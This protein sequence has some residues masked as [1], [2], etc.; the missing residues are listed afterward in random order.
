MQLRARRAAATAVTACLCVLLLAGGAAARPAPEKHARHHG[1]GAKSAAAQS[2]S[3]SAAR[4][5]PLRVIAIGDSITQGSVPSANDNHPYTLEL[6]RRLEEAKLAR[7]VD[8]DNIAV[9]GAGVFAVGFHNPV[10]LVPWA[11]SHLEKAK[12]DWAVV[13]VGINDLLRESRRADDVSGGRALLC[14]LGGL[15][16]GWGGRRC[17]CFGRAVC[18]FAACVARGWR[19]AAAAAAAALYWREASEQA[20]HAHHPLPHNNNNHTTPTHTTQVMKGLNDIYQTAL[21]TGA[22]VLAIAPLPAPGFVSQS[23]YKEAERLKLHEQIKAAAAQWTKD[24]PKGPAFEVLDLGVGGPMNFWA[25]GDSERSQ[26]LDDGLHL[27]R[28]AYDKMG[29]FIADALI[30]KISAAFAAHAHGG[31]AQQ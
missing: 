17:R 8:V 15:R 26:W 14:F 5:R 16:C 29:N 30:P 23:D 2:G 28:T 10:T 9:G 7:K 25:M 18:A 11:Q 1:A 12:Y 13:L 20:A 19:R 4:G 22:N 21:K 31:H 24:H 6:T 27:T 3:A